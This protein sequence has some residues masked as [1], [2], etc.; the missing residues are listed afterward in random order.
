MLWIFLSCFFAEA[1]SADKL[2]KGSFLQLPVRWGK[3]QWKK[4]FAYM[5]DIGIDELII[6][7]V[8]HDTIIFYESEFTDW[9]TPV[10]ETAF[11]DT[12]LQVCDSMGIDVYMGTWYYSPIF[13]GLYWHPDTLDTCKTRII[14]IVKEVWEKFGSH[15]CIKGWYITPEVSYWLADPYCISD[16]VGKVSRCW[17]EIA[18]S[19]H[20]LTP[21]KLVLASPFFTLKYIDPD[22]TYRIDHNGFAVWVDS[23]ACLSGVDVLVMQDGVG[24]LDHLTGGYH[25]DLD[26]VPI[27]YEIIKNVLDNYP[28]VHFWSHLEVYD[29]TVPPW[30]DTIFH[31]ADIERVLSQINCE[32]P[33]VEKIVCFEFRHYMEPTRVLEPWDTWGFRLK[34][35]KL[36]DGYN[37]HFW[38]V[39]NLTSKSS[40]ELTPSPSSNYPDDRNKLIDTIIPPPLYDYWDDYVGWQNVDSI[41][42]KL[43]LGGIDTVRNIRTYLLQDN[44]AEIY[45]PTEVK[46]FISPDDTNYSFIGTAKG[47][48][49]DDSLDVTVPFSW[50]DSVYTGRWIK[51]VIFPGGEWT[52]LSEV[53]VFGIPG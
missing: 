51:L 40:Y 14:A 29:K 47:F 41:V 27:Y 25:V 46:V 49:P 8:A 30:G 15:S 13:K 10:L 38:D 11:L 12:V 34:N 21:G 19:C 39:R 45:L 26:S 52:F 35:A 6:Q 2:I 23:F 24:A 1:E 31:A 44:S 22:S 32:S 18:D 37:E 3:E 50:I 20:A 4:E 17:K 36:Y 16:N 5:T 53:Q 43:D 33:Y 9:F 7:Y 28:D 48:R 42:V